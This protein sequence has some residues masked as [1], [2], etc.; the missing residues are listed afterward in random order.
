MRQEGTVAEKVSREERIKAIEKRRTIRIRRSSLTKNKLDDIDKPAIKIAET[1][2][3]YRQAFNIVYK[4]YDLVGYIT[5]PHPAQLHYGIHSLLPTTCV[6]TFKSCM[7]VIS[8][9]TQ[10]EDSRLFGLPMDALYKP[11]IDQLRAQGRKV[12]EICALATPSEGR[13]HNLLMFLGKAYFQYALEAK[14]N[15]ILIMVNPKHVTFYKA[16]FMFEEFAEER[17]YG[18]VGAPAVALR[19]N[20][21]IFW[22]KLEEAFRDQE[23]ETDLYTFFR[24]IHNAGV[25]RYMKFSGAR[26]IPLD[27]DAAR[28]FFQVRPE[29]LENL[30]EEQLEYIE[31]IYHKALYSAEDIQM[32]YP[33]TV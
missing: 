24:R 28:Y 16:I 14:V 4:E 23:F 5:K 8:T 30:N 1:L 32:R 22:E 10:V 9:L 13:W 27:Y 11:E 19:I 20:Y 6:F 33:V 3:E 7:D 15:D 17:Y 26:N 2:D 31:T 18:P 12:A 29:L 25:D 21:D